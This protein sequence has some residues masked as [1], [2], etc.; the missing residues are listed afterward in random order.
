MMADT[1]ASASIAAASF[2][3]AIRRAANILGRSRHA[4]IAGM[5]TDAA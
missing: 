4:V 5:A 1:A 3:N 2:D